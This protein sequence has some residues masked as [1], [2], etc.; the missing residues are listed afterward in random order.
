MEQILLKRY[1][2]K[3]DELNTLKVYQ[4]V[5]DAETKQ[6][7]VNEFNDILIDAYIEGFSSASYIL[8]DISV[9]E[10]LLTESLDKEYDGVSIQEKI[11]TYY[12]QKDYVSAKALIESEYHRVYNKARENAYADKG[13]SKLWLTVGDDKVRETHSFLDGVTVNAGERFYTIDGDSALYPGDF[14]NAENNANCRCVVDY[15]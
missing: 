5:I 12:E 2:T 14:E 3:F 6:D 4:K 10:V 11:G 7:A 1:L 9:D 15:K 13:Y 8:G